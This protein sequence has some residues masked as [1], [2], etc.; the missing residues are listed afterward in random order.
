MQTT[1]TLKNILNLI[2]SYDAL[3]IVAFFIFQTKTPL[4]MTAN[5]RTRVLMLISTSQVVAQ[6]LVFRSMAEK[7][8]LTLTTK[9][10]ASSQ[11]SSQAIWL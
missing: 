2:K 3:Y 10:L 8:I 11:A 9:P 7:P 1:H 4:P 6:A 5:K